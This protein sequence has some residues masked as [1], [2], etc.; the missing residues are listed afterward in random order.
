MPSRISARAADSHPTTTPP[1]KFEV[2][3]LSYEAIE[4]LRPL[5]EIIRHSDRDLAKQI[6]LRPLR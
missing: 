2:L 3:A 5:V 6:L 1:M 4:A